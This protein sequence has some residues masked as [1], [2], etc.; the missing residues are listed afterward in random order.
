MKVYKSTLPL[1][2][3]LV[4]VASFNT[5]GQQKKQVAGEIFR[6]RDMQEIVLTGHPIIMQAGLLSKTAQARVLQ[7]LGNFDPAVAA[8]FG[9][10]KFGG[11]EY[12]NHWNSQLKI[13][14]WLAG[15]DLNVG[16]DRNV[17]V[18]NNPETRT[19]STGLSAIGLSIPLG[20]GLLIDARRNTLRQA[21]IMVGYAEAEKVEK[22]NSVWISAVKD[23]WNWYFAV[24]QYNYTEEGVA[25]AEKRFLGLRAQVLI[26]DKP[27][28][29]SVEASITLQDR[30]VQLQQASVK[31]NNSRLLLSNHLWNPDGIPQELPVSAVPE[32][33]VDVKKRMDNFQLDSLTA[34]AA[35]QHPELLKIKSEQVQLNVEEQ[36]RLEMLKPKLNL[37]GSFI[38]GRR[39]FSYVPDRYDFQSANYKFGIDFSF[40][41]FLRAERG[42][43]REVRVKQAQVNYG[44]QQTSREIQTDILASFNEF[45]AYQNQLEL[46]AK[47]VASQRTLVNGELQK[48]ELGESNLFL[49]N[50]RETKL[51]EMQVKLAELVSSLQKAMADIY[52][53]AGKR[54]EF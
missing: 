20:Q 35:Q 45:K 18:Y 13:P 19:N 30:I 40:P 10:K 33:D 11:T 51:I 8:S 38:A 29:D 47:N 7:S 24:Q 37:K 52:Y 43:L 50:A 46:Q 49:I 17:G 23:Y 4:W 44:L 5:S 31:L 34:H 27:P 14:L 36:Y 39:D 53:K 21:K 16:Y 3:L 6:L 25:L 42:K 22:I 32:T 28:I 26:G 15:A 48:L 54:I 9:S 41:L 1:V 2:F 12:Y